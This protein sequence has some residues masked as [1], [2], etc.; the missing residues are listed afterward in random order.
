VPVLFQAVPRISPETLTVP[1]FV[2]DH[3]NVFQR[4]VPAAT[5]TTPLLT[6]EALAV[7]TPSWVKGAMKMKV[8]VRSKRAV[9]WKVTRPVPKPTAPIWVYGTP[10][11]WE[12]WPVTVS[13]PV[14]SP[15]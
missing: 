9:G 11:A 2:T 10:G 12:T 8:L 4:V 14:M 3:P 13:V 6:N 15:V 5:L 7:L 1:A